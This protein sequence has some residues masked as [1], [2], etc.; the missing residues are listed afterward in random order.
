[1]YSKWSAAY[2]TNLDIS[3]KLSFS[4]P[5]VAPSINSTT[6]TP[7]VGEGSDLTLTCYATGTPSPS[8]N[9]IRLDKSMPS[10]AQGVDS[11]TLV[12]P[13]IDWSD[14]GVYVCLAF[15][16]LGRTQSKPIYV[17]MQAQAGTSITSSIIGI[18]MMI[19]SSYHTTVYSNSNSTTLQSCNRMVC[20]SIYLYFVLQLGASVMKQPSRQ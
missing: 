20:D 2:V 13:Q 10:K 6:T 16:E 19:E 14:I 3:L 7:T 17:I 11:S 15:N 1:M 4:S 9:W 12:I 18:H 5:A 8:Y